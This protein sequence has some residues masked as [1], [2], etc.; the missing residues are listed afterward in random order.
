MVPKLHAKGCSFKN[1]V[2]RY[3]LKDKGRAETAERVA[4]TATRNLAT[5]NPNLAWRLQAATAMDADRLKASAGV[6]NT[7]R[8]SKDAVAHLSLAWHPERDGTVDREEMERAADLAIRALGAEDHQVI[9]VAHCDGHPHIHVVINRVNP[10]NGKMLSSSKEKLRLSKFALDYE[11]GRGE[12]LCEERALNWEARERGQYVRGEKAIPRNIYKRHRANDSRPDKGEHRLKHS[13]ADRAVGRRQRETRGRQAAAWAKLEADHRARRSAILD[14]RR[15]ES[16]RA[17]D[18]I[19]AEFRLEKFGPLRRKQRAELSSFEHGEQR[20][21]GRVKNR[22]KG[23]DLKSL[24][25]RVKR[26]RSVGPLF[27]A[28]ASSGV[29]LDRLKR[30]HESQKAALRGLER[31]EITGATRAIRETARAEL[32][33]ARGAFESERAA[34]AFRCAGE[35]AKLRAERKQR[36]VDRADNNRASVERER[37]MKR[38]L[39]RRAKERDRNHDADD[40]GR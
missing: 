26:E 31:R 23:L 19:R 38:L 30:R 35:S 25:G 20:L 4:W 14:R 17:R 16:L 6:K 40:R 11:R 36:A 21:M 22:F 15:V 27:D 37:T 29:A 2:A 33:I 3:L 39:E 5:S 12:I 28:I 13:E 9:I 34:L 8:K 1:L 7:G 24:V 10:T 18:A 32:V